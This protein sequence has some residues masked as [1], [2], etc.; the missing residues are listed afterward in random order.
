MTAPLKLPQ[1][2]DA[3]EA[4][5]KFDGPGNRGLYGAA[6]AKRDAT[7]N[8]ARDTQFPGALEWVENPDRTG[9]PAGTVLALIVTVAGG[10]VRIPLG[11]TEAASLISKLAGGLA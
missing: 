10:I 8:I 6:D 11:R 7:R 1:V 2:S 4:M 3:I 9:D 5:D